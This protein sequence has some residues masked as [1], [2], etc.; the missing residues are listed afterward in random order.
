MTKHNFLVRNV[1][2]LADPS[3]SFYIAKRA[4]RPS[5]WSPKD[6]TIWRRSTGE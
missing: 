3:V 6:V 5:W 2:E 4:D 1:E